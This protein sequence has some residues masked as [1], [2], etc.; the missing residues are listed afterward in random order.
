VL[1]VHCVRA[2]RH[3]LCSGRVLTTTRTRGRVD[4][5]ACDVMR[6]CM[7]ASSVL[8]IHHTLTRSPL[9]H[10]LDT[11]RLYE[12]HSDGSIT[13]TQTDVL[14][15]SM[16]ALSPT[17]AYVLACG[18]VPVDG[19]QVYVQFAVYYRVQCTQTP[20]LS[21]LPLQQRGRAVRVDWQ[22]GQRRATRGGVGMCTSF[23]LTVYVFV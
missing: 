8:Y 6:V 20:S 22:G 19:V 2:S 13:R 9:V 17:G 18:V 10:R 23:A 21:P 15:L 16:F 3:V 11:D 1:C 4:T 7:C 14:S 12:T 5:G